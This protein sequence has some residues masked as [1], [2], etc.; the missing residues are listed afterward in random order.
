[1]SLPAA[2]TVGARVGIADTGTSSS[3]RWRLTEVCELK[4]APF[5]AHVLPGTVRPRT[6]IPDAGHAYHDRTTSTRRYRPARVDIG[7]CSAGHTLGWTH[8]GEWTAYTV[9]VA[10]PGRYRVS[11][12]V[13]SGLD[14]AAMHLE[15]D[16]ADLTGRIDIPNTR[17]F[18][19]WAVVERI[20]TLA[21]GEQVL[22]VVIDGDYVNLNRMVFEAAE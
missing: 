5:K 14:G 15:S 12:H 8:S 1:L 13:A 17:G 6:T 11:L 4:Q 21:A 10:K 9:R 2:A 22:R 16:G 7:D 19:N 20:V 18:Q 3:S